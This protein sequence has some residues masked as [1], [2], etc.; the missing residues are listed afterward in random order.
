MMQ[1]CSVEQ[2]CGSLGLACDGAQVAFVELQL[3][4]ALLEGNH[5][6]N[7]VKAL[8]ATISCNLIVQAMT[9]SL[10]LLR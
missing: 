4:I 3:T 9:S 8:G 2:D 5:L 6:C 7:L 10:Q 1:Y